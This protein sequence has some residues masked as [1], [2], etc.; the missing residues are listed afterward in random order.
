MR[1]LAFDD[2]SQPHLVLSFRRAPLPGERRVRS[3]SIQLPELEKICYPV[4]ADRLG[5]ETRELRIGLLEP[6]PLADSVGLIAELLGP[7]LI[8]IV[9]NIVLENLCVH[10]R[11]AVHRVA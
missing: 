7:N 1:V 10:C 9:E 2:L 4:L 3:K 5:N 8:K 6:A 11:H